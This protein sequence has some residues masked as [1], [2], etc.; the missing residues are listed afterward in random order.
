M[1]TTILAAA[2]L[3]AVTVV[4]PMLPPPSEI[5]FKGNASCEASGCSAFAESGQHS[6]GSSDGAPRPDSGAT[7][8]L[9]AE[10]PCVEMDQAEPGWTCVASTRSGPGGVGTV[11][12]R[13]AA[14]QARASM[15]LPAPALASSPAEDTIVHFPVWLWV[16]GADWEPVSATASVSAGSVTVTA[17]PQQL[18]WDMGDG[19]VLYCDGPGTVFDPARHDSQKPSPD[20]G[21]AYTRTSRN[22]PDSRFLV[23]ATVSWTVGWTTSAGGGGTLD[24]LTTSASD[25]VRVREVHALV[26][27]G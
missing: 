11:S 10:D 5:D 7:A 24:P 3:P 4:S 8:V 13:E 27:D 19:T 20:C 16:D 12:P 9:S 1:S 14:E 2:V 22:Q 23:A 17:V 18:R 21:H 26:T 25:S 6:G 15:S